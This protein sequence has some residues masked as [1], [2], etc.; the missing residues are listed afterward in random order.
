M[1]KRNVAAISLALISIGALSFSLSATSKVEFGPPVIVEKTKVVI[2]EQ[3][4]PLASEKEMNCLATNIYFEAMQ[5]SFAGQ[6]AVSSVVLN[7][8]ADA[9]FPN[10]I[11]GVVQQ[12][13]FGSASKEVSKGRCQFSWYCDGKPDTIRDPKA[14]SRVVEVAEIAYRMHKEGLDITEGATHYH[15][16]YVRPA[17]RRD[18]G[19]RRVGKIDTHIFYRWRK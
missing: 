5:E 4:I 19:M 8:V 1:L 18:R 17:W 15:A 12:G 14:W 6:L 10:S 7:R 2:K 3:E 13:A 9:R 11:C 16:T